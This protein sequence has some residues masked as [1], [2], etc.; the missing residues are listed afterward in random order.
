MSRVGKKPITIEEGVNVE[1]DG[2]R[3][4]V[5]GPKGEQE[6]SL[7]D[8]L[9]AK[10][11]EDQLQVELRR[12]TKRGPALWGLW[13][14]LLQNSV[15]GVKQG[16]EKKLELVGIGYRA[17]LKDDVLELGV[18]YSRPVQY[19]LAPDIQ[20]TV[21]KNVITISGLDKQRV[22]QV[23]A[24]IR[25]VRKPEPYKGKGIRYLGEEIRLKPGKAAKAAAT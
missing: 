10:Q 3:L 12:K 5:S 21:E 23:A 19:R 11:I 7:P 20:A 6:L 8:E 16:F 18:G 15:R 14:S 25:S 22:G 4:K 9:V 1:I 2:Q 24:E 13:R 17:N